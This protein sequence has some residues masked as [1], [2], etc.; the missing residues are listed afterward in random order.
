M[1]KIGTAYS[2]LELAAI[3]R[4]STIHQV[5]GNAVALAQKAEATG[6][7]RMWFA[8]HHNMQAIASTAPQILIGHVAQ[9]TSTLRVGSGGIMLPNHSPFIIAEQF[10]TLAHLFPG[11]IDLGLGRAPGTDPETTRAITAG[12]MEATQSFPHDIGKIQTYFSKENGSAKIRVALAEGVE[13]PIFVLGS[14]TSSA[15]LA[16]KKGLPYAFASH[17]STAHFLD[18]IRIYR[19]RFEPSAALK[20]PY[21]MAGINTFVADTDQQAERLYTS[22]LRLVIDILSGTRAAFIEAPVEMTTELKEIM[23]H[24]RVNQ[25]TQYS[26][27]GGKEKVKGQVQEFLK[28]VQVDELITVS[29]M[30]DIK[31]RLR[32]IE[33]FGEIMMEINQ[34]K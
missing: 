15:Q 31:D 5:Y 19:D 6:Y 1:N 25:M 4:E 34:G 21:V 2:I 23:Q 16:A 11:R 28:Q 26:F 27:I 33:L 10:G 12:F 18:A 13:V 24:P 9:A 7:K 30:Y 17:F 8:E 29:T 3:S 32:S 20:R 22:N 14:S